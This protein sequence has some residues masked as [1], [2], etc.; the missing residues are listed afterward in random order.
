MV[1]NTQSTVWVMSGRNTIN[2]ITSQSLF[3]CPDISQSLSSG[4]HPQAWRR[5]STV[6]WGIFGPRLHSSERLCWTSGPG[7]MTTKKKK[8]AC[9]RMSRPFLCNNGGQRGPVF[10]PCKFGSLRSNTEHDFAA[11]FRPANELRN[12]MQ[13]IVQA[14]V[15]ITSPVC[16]CLSFKSV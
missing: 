7:R 2:L 16:L 12:R 13:R 10:E 6:H 14:S 5:N 9:A 4:H 11:E 3:T 1:F 8:C 15:I